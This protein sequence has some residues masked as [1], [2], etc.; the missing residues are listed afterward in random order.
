M[1]MSVDFN[2]NNL[3]Q[4]LQGA[5]ER[6]DKRIKAG[7]QAVSR[8]MVREVTGREGL[9]KYPRHKKGTPTPSPVGEPPAQVTTNLRRSV[10]I[11]PARR[12]GFGNYEQTVQNTA[13]YARVQ[14]FGSSR[15]PKRPFMAPARKRTMQKADKLFVRA[16]ILEVKRGK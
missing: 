7:V 15:I 4:F 9:S 14:E 12:I 5:S 11:Q 3:S 13:I 6:I 16:V 1:Q 2:D 8:E 10:K